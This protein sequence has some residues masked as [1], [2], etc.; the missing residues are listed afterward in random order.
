MISKKYFPTIFISALALVFLIQAIAATALFLTPVPVQAADPFKLEVP[1][2]SLS[3]IPMGNSTEPI[4]VYIK[5]IYNFAVGAVGIVAAVVLMIGGVTWITAGGNASTVGEAKS[6]IGAALTGMVLVLTSY[7]LLDQVNPSLVNLS[8][9]IA[10]ITP[11]PTTTTAA[12]PSNCVWTELSINQY[13]K[14]VKGVDWSN[15]DGDKCSG[16]SP[17]LAYDCCCN[18]QTAAAASGTGSCTGGR[19]AL[20]DTYIANAAQKYGVD[21][22]LIK[23]L[24]DIGEGCNPN[25]PAPSLHSS[26][27]GYAQMLSYNRSWCGFAGTPSETCLAI[28]SD[29]QA[30]MDC[31]AKFIQSNMGHSCLTNI[32]TIAS[33]YAT[34]NPTSCGNPGDEGYCTRVTNFYNTC[35]NE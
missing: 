22:K 24:V 10:T 28:Q 2:G 3:S 1:I 6:M 18:Q 13:C 34:G 19:C 21:A 25:Q 33:C 12:A 23:G 31:V 14:D 17:G 32:S 29:H 27:C 8:Q 5:T 4:A 30:D 15:S 9:D 11:P 20:L 35:T 16:S 7:L 26:A